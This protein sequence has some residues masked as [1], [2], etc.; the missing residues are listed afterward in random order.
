MAISIL[1]R[2]F[3]K[4]YDPGSFRF[5]MMRIPD[6]YNYINYNDEE[7]LYRIAT[8]AEPMRVKREAINN[9]MVNRGFK[10]FASGTNRVVYQY[11]EDT[12][13]VVK[14]A[15]DRTGLKDNPAEFEN[16]MKLKP[17]VCKVFQVSKL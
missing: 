6:L 7:S 5:D 1:D 12:T 17:F 13:F 15:L 4:E 8:S 11:L 2:L 3:A 14:I 16:Q 9:I 10:R